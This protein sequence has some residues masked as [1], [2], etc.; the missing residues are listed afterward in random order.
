MWPD[1]M[2]SARAGFMADEATAGGIDEAGAFFAFG[3]AIS[4]QEGFAAGGVKGDV[5]AGGEQ[6]VDVLDHLDL[7]IEGGFGEIEFVVGDDFHF[8]GQGAFG[9]GLSDAAKADD[10]E[11]F[12]GELRA[13]ETFAVPFS[14]AEGGIGE[15]NLAREGHHEGEGVFGGGDGVGV[16]GVHDQDAGFGGGFDIDIVH[17]D[18]GAGDGLKLAGIGEFVFFDLDAGA[19]DHAVV[20]PQDFGEFAGLPFF[21]DGEFDV[22]LGFEDGETL[23]RERI[24]HKNVEHGGT[25]QNS[26]KKGRRLRRSERRSIG[27]TRKSQKAW[28]SVVG[29]AR[30]GDQALGGAWAFS[31]ETAGTWSMQARISVCRLPKAVCMA[32]MSRLVEADSNCWVRWTSFSAASSRAKPRREW[33]RA[34]SVSKSWAARDFS[35][36][37]E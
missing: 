29:I 5:I 36:A 15:R 35:R 9:D 10:A 7:A 18:T 22:R 20:L 3:E 27:Q 13:H 28:R 4:A 11:C 16:G 19:D 34:L 8:E 30:R 23:G 25:P 32:E 37:A 33:V 2:A 24:G 26:D 17:A 14:G 21:L 6:G 31:E 1:L 12:S